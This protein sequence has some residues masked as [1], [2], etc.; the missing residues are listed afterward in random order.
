MMR[1]SCGLHD[2]CVLPRHETQCFWD[3]FW[4]D[5]HRDHPGEDTQGCSAGGAYQD[6]YYVSRW[7]LVRRQQLQAHDRGNTNATPT[8]GVA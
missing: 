8:R 1:C 6:G 7:A 3:G 4:G 5:Y 2:Y